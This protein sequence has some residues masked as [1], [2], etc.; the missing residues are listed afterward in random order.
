MEIKLGRPLPVGVGRVSQWFGSHPEWYQKFS[1]AGHNGLDYS[2]PVGTPVLA[3]HTGKLEYRPC[4]LSGY[5]INVMIRG[6]NFDTR[7]A[8]LNA[9]I[10]SDGAE[11]KVGDI[12]A[13]SGNSGNSTGPHLHFA[14]TVHGMKNQAYGGYI[15]PAPF[16]ED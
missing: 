16:R 6:T 7:Y 13:M 3:T 8:H 14:L 9:I 1:Y 5:G 2:T 12:I 15:D 4:D 11:V 10:M